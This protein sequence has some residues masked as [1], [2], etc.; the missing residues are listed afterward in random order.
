[1]QYILLCGQVVGSGPFTIE[2][3]FDGRRFDERAAAIDHGFKAGRSDDFNIGVLRD[4]KLV[5]LDWMDRTVDASPGTL[6]EISKMVG[7]A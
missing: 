3:G 1:M 4:D 7:L 2:Y 6:A 5:S